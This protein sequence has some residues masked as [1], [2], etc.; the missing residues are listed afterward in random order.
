MSAGNYLIISDLQI[1]FEHND[2][3]KFCFHLKHHYKI[4]DE[5]ILNVGDELD[6]YWG[7]LWDKSPE[8]AHTVLHLSQTQMSPASGCR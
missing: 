8:A 1:P 5:N 4:P 2:A 3:L 6:Q 7:G